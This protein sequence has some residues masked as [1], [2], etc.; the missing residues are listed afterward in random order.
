[1]SRPFT[2]LTLIGHRGGHELMLSIHGRGTRQR[3][4]LD[5][6]LVCS[7]SGA[8][9][10][11]TLGPAANAFDSSSIRDAVDQLAATVLG[12]PARPAADEL[13]PGKYETEG[14]SPMPRA[15]PAGRPVA[16]VCERCGNSMIYE[17]A[18]REPLLLCPRCQALECTY[19]IQHLG[20]QVV[21]VARQL[22]H[23]VRATSAHLGRVETQSLRR[24]LRGLTRLGEVG[25]VADNR[26]AHSD[27]K[28]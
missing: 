26:R 23:Q 12:A 11:V 18:A 5:G 28:A 9:G 22:T 15:L 24:Q 16:L 8:T 2:R 19:R 21:T 20:E 25:D 4:L 7:R 3:V 6:Q 14:E 10:E 17:S 1:M 13:E 27:V